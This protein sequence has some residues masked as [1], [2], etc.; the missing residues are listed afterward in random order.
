MTLTDIT[1]KTWPLGK[2]GH[3]SAYG[4]QP[5]DFNS[6]TFTL[7]FPT[8]PF[9]F[10]ATQVVRYDFTTEPRFINDNTFW[11]DM[12]QAYEG[13][14]GDVSFQANELPAPFYTGPYIESNFGLSYHLLTA[15]GGLP[16]T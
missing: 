15:T 16:K 7:A 9:L 10:D 6:A 11:I 14:V 3:G 5:G 4:L 2:L 8:D 1:G 12:L 13:H